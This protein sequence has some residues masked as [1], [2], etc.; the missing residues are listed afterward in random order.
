MDGTDNTNGT[1]TMLFLESRSNDSLSR[2]G[3]AVCEA[4]RGGSE[5]N[6]LNQPRRTLIRNSRPS[7]VVA[8]TKHL[9]DGPPV[10]GKR[11]W[12]GLEGLDAC[13]LWPARRFSQGQLNAS[14]SAQ[15]HRP[16]EARGCWLCVGFTVSDPVPHL[17]FTKHSAP[18]ANVTQS[19]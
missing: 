17:K 19:R 15:Y 6:V 11:R 8:C 2:G 12:E 13:T 9:I 7:G 4:R 3:T 14:A 16:T 5:R 1:K 18:A 10:E